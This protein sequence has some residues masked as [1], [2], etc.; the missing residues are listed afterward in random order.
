[1]N[2]KLMQIQINRLLIPQKTFCFS[3]KFREQQGKKIDH[4][5]IFAL[6]YIQSKINLKKITGN[7]S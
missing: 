3:A 2:V 1:M 6:N 7:V 5:S 4:S